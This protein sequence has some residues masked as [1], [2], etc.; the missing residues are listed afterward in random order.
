MKKFF[1]ILLIAWSVTGNCQTVSRQLAGSVAT[2]HFRTHYAES[3]VPQAIISI[4]KDSTLCFYHV[5]MSNGAWC[6]VPSTMLVEPILMYGTEPYDTTDLAPAF[7]ELI[8]WYKTQIDIIIRGTDV[9][10]SIHSAWNY[11]LNPDRNISNYYAGTELLFEARNGVQ[12]WRQTSNN[13]RGCSPSY[14]QDCPEIND[15]THPCLPN[16]I[17]GLDTCKCGR[18]PTGCAAVA[19]GQ[20]MWYWQWPRESEYR[21]YHW[22]NMPREINNNTDPWEASNISRLLRDC[23]RAADI[24]YCCFGSWTTANNIVDAFHQTFQYQSVHKYYKEDWDFGTAWNDLIKSEIDNRRPVIM[25]GDKNAWWDGHFFVL[26]GYRCE[27]GMTLYHV[28]WGHGQSNNN[29]CY[30]QIN[31]FHEIIDDDTIIRSNH[32]RALVGIAPWYNDENITSLNYTAV[33]QY[34]RR[35]E[36]AYNKVSVPAAGSSLTVEVDGHF[37]IEAGNEVVLQPGFY[38]RF[39]SEVDIHIDPTWQDHKTISL[40][41]ASSNATIGQDYCIETKN[42]DSWEFL[43]YTITES[44]VLQT[45]GSITSDITCIWD[46]NNLQNGQYRCTLVLKNSYGRMYSNDYLLVVNNVL[47]S[48]DAMEGS[49]IQCEEQDVYM[50]STPL[51]TESSDLYPN[52]TSGE[53]TVTVDGEVQGIILY[54]A[55]GQPVG[56]WKMLSMGGGR[57]TL[58]VSNLPAGP[59]LIR[60]ATPSGTVTKK[61][62]VQRR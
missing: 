36:Y 19:M 28:N 30:C 4:Y 44:S 50:E 52:P 16:G 43:V 17:F 54:N 13:D 60:I 37:T 3:I 15:L 2:S 1:F 56:G 20:V 40:V 22:E 5:I 61:L 55:Q 31:L 57:L 26:D 18:K 48:T 42:A 33:P 29:D 51:Y 45:A 11:L 53:V 41:S 39:G 38:A 47:E 8:E 10:R 12:K 25:Y 34:N 21:T 27:N 32:N 9:T 49:G 6:F 46:G 62:V 58:D 7:V 23:G 59:Y 24:H 14:N 35:F